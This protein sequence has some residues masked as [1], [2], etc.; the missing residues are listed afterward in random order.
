[1]TRQNTSP[2]SRSARLE[3]AR[4]WVLAALLLTLLSAPA[5]QAASASPAPDGPF[6]IH[7]ASFQSDI[8]ASNEVRQ[9]TAKGWASFSRKVSLPRKGTWWRV[10]VGPYDSL[11]KA[12][13][14]AALLKRQ[15][16]SRYAAVERTGDE[17]TRRPGPPPESSPP[18][19]APG[20]PATGRI[21]FTDTTTVEPAGPSAAAGHENPVRPAAPDGPAVPSTTIPCRE[22]DC[23]PGPASEARPVWTEPVA[24]ASTPA[25]PPALLIPDS[26]PAGQAE[27]A[28]AEKTKT[29]D[30]VGRDLQ[31]EPAPAALERPAPPAPVSAVEGGELSIGSHEPTGMAKEQPAAAAAPRPEAAGPAVAKEEPEKAPPVYPGDRPEARKHYEKANEYVAKGML[32]IAVVNYSRAIELDPSYAEAYNGRGL[33]YEAF[34]RSDLAIADYDAAVRLKPDYDEAILNRALACS[35]TGR[36]D[37]AK[38]DLQS[39]CAL[40]NR[41]A[42]DALGNMRGSGRP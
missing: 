40:K 22:G 39:A 11:A 36:F 32:E 3:A 13:E 12:E 33:A 25:T 17:A 29:E 34:Q 4:T 16:V 37:Q 41:R 6:S 23:G 38:R 5:V 8:N 15:G 14:Q 21:F 7:I 18:A 20:M 10:Y 9:L 27:P 31:A 30:V 42:C 28:M 2:V 1:M 26:R 19:P 35:H 24:K